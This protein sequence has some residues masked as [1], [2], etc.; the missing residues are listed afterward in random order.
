FV[1]SSSIAE[2]QQ[3]ATTRRVGE[4]GVSLNC[5][6]S[7]PF[8]ASHAI[9]SVPQVGRFPIGIEYRGRGWK[10]LDVPTDCLRCIA[11]A[12]RATR[13]PIEMRVMTRDCPQAA[14]LSDDV[15]NYWTHN[16]KFLWKLLNARIA[17]LFGH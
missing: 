17:M 14:Q 13:P 6:C 11:D 15:P 4:S 16:G 10:L 9:P 7:L 1:N 8:C 5:K 3:E 12:L 2:L